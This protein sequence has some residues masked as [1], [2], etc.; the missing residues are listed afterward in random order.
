MPALTPVCGG[1]RNYQVVAANHTLVLNWNAQT[2]PLLRQIAI[3]R[4]ER[5][6]GTYS[7]CVVIHRFPIN[8]VHQWE[9]TS[10][11]AMWHAADKSSSIC[12]ALQCHLAFA[13][14]MQADAAAWRFSSVLKLVGP[15]ASRQL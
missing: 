4:S 13:V 5:G 11:A 6:E 8:S 1:C 3:N 2:V 7:G 10:C 9:S 12:L 15:V 14:V